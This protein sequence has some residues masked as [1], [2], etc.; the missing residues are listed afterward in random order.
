MVAR[1]AKMTSSSANWLVHVARDGLRSIEGGSATAKSASRSPSLISS[2]SEEALVVGELCARFCAEL[3]VVDVSERV[4]SFYSS[5]CNE[6]YCFF[7]ALT[8][9]RR[10]A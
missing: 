4:R 6:A 2:S 9:W 1:P 8:V 5:I 10:A 7:V 3:G